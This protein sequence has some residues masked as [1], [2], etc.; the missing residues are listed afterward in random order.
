MSNP[1]VPI[2][3]RILRGNPGKRAF[4]RGLEPERPAE[5]P[6]PPPFLVGYAADEWWRVA[7]GLHQLGLL[8]V[9][10]VGPLSA[11]CQAYSHWRTASETLAAMAE[12]DGATHGLMVKRAS[13]G[14]PMRN[15]LVKIAADAASDMVR[16][17][18]EFGFSPAARARISAGVAYEPPGGK[19]SGL[20]A[21]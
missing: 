8:S 7:P 15:P 5:P 1:P 6:E 18:A 14:N 11:Y 13:D 2:P 3:L 12:R 21:E 4:R 19:F 9:L 16:Y 10:D 20:L 17:A